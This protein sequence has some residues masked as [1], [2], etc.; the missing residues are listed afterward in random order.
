M[1][2]YIFK[3][4]RAAREQEAGT[5]KTGT[6]KTGAGRL[7]L[8]HTFPLAPLTEAEGYNRAAAQLR[9]LRRAADPR[10]GYY[11]HL[12]YGNDERDAGTKLLALLE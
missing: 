10:A 3:V 9:E 11:L 7:E 4:W 8:L 5:E 1:P 6:E 12:V 2:F